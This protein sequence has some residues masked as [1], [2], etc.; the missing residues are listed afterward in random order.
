[1][2]RGMEK[3]STYVHFVANADASI[4]VQDRN[5]KVTQVN[6]K[7]GEKLTVRGTAPWRIQTT[8]WADVAVFFQGYRMPVPA[9]ATLVTLNP[10]VEP[11]SEA[12][13]QTN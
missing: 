9:S 13:A 4:C 11:L 6:L 5:Q 2:P 10:R 12:T 8:Q 1:M 3:P 7:A